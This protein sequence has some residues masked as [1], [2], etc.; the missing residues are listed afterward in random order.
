MSNQLVDI[1]GLSL[2]S[3]FNPTLLAAVAVMMLLSSPKR[4]MA[5]YLLGAN[6]SSITLGLVI[7]FALPGS[8]T[9]STSKHTTGPLE[10]IAVGLL[11]GDFLELELV[12]L[13]RSMCSDPTVWWAPSLHEEPHSRVLAGL[14]P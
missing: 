13:A 6:T 1:F 12:A 7:V 3:M 5:G 10:D 4:L 2:V 8:S 9:E 11:A 14:H